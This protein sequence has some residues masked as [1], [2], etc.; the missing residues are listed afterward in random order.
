MGKSLEA[1]K[2]AWDADS[3]QETLSQPRWE[4]VQHRRSFDLT[5]VHALAH[6]RL[7][8]I[9]MNKVVMAP[10]CGGLS[11]LLGAF[12]CSHENAGPL[13]RDGKACGRRA[14]PCRGSLGFWKSRTPGPCTSTNLE[15]HSDY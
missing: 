10:P 13:L 4:P 8:P 15:I 6:L 5:C 3:R 11:I 1:G 2:L 14:V 12:L 9:H 7:H